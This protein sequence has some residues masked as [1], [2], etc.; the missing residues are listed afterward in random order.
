MT[1]HPALAARQAPLLA[2]SPF[3]SA[4]LWP[5]LPLALLTA[6]FRV[7]CLTTFE[8]CVFAALLAREPEAVS[9]SNHRIARDAPTKLLRNRAGGLP[10]KPKGASA[11]P[12]VAR[13]TAP[14]YRL[15][16]LLASSTRLW[17]VIP[18]EVLIHGSA[19][20]IRG[21]RMWSLARC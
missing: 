18:T 11:A 15:P 20:V 9:L 8:S 13:P 6:H 16:I 1:T 17:S 5:R 19:F 2:L 10:G 14:S 3:A 7:S 21:R 12:F 4:V